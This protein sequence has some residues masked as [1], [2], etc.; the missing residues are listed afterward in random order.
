VTGRTFAGLMLAGMAA[1]GAW[2]W[3]LYL[4]DREDIDPSISVEVQGVYLRDAIVVSPG[5]DGRP[6]Y[7]LVAAEMTQ[8]L[9]ATTLGIR[10]VYLEYESSGPGRWTVH[11]D[12]GDVALDW[13][14]IRLS[15]NVSVAWAGERA[16]PTVLETGTLKLDAIAHRASTSERVILH[17]GGGQIEGTGMSV[18]LMAGTVA[19]ESRVN[20]YFA[21]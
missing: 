15:G 7:R 10:D 13:R 3:Q 20:G 5:P 1:F 17:R 19:L 11:S 21:P 8:P 9:D 2:R 6:L 12:R 16:P 18:D 14:D 4:Q